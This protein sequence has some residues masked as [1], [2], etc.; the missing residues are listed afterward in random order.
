MDG[1]REP[2]W[3]ELPGL[4][5]CLLQ[6]DHVSLPCCRQLFN[7]FWLDFNGG[8]VTVTAVVE[9]EVTLACTAVVHVAAPCELESK[10]SRM[11]RNVL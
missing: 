9:G 3:A 2:G 8:L 4:E 1:G 7:S 11:G 10:L 6:E 5:D